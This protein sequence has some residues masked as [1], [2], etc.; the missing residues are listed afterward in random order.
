MSLVEDAAGNVTF[1]LNGVA[2]PA[3]G[4]VQ[5]IQAYSNKLGTWKPRL[6]AITWFGADAKK[7]IGSIGAV[8]GY[9]VAHSASEVAAI[10][11]TVQQ[12]H[13]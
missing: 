7:F 10:W 3:D 12:W 1:Y 6:G 9:S 13:A 4:G 2:V 5:P 8:A 11:D